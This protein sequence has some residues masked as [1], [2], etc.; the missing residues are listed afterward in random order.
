MEMNLWQLDSFQKNY[1]DHLQLHNP[2]KKFLLVAFD[3]KYVAYFQR[4]KS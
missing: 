3:C 1:A 2:T 4:Q